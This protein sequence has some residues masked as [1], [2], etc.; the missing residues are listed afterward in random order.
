LKYKRAD[1]VE[2]TADL[3][4]PPGYK[5]ESGPLPGFVWA[6]PREFKSADAAGQ[7]KGSPYTFHPIELGRSDLLGNAWLCGIRQCLYAYCW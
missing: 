1:G 4:L 5:K 7:V 2:L 6:Y 3:Y